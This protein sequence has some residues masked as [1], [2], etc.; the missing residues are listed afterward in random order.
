VADLEAVIEDD[1]GDDLL[2]LMFTRIPF[3]AP[4]GTELS[5]RLASVLEGIYLV[6]NEG[7]LVHG[8]LALMEIQASRSMASVGASGEPV[9]SLDQNRALGSAPFRNIFAQRLIDELHLAFR[10]IPLWLG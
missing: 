2:R 3:E 1:L 7:C 10:P 4:R 9:L 5:T 6:F 8:L